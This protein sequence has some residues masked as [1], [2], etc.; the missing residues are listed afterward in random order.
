[1]QG[2]ASNTSRGKRATCRACGPKGNQAPNTSA[3]DFQQPP[4]GLALADNIVPKRKSVD[5]RRL[6]EPLQVPS[7]SARPIGPGA[8]QDPRQS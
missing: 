3:N 7:E 4:G 1:M 5:Q 2:G 6:A 8:L